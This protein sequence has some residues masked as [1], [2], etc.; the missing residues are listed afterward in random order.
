M[1]LPMYKEWKTRLTVKKSVSLVAQKK[2]TVITARYVPRTMPV[3]K[4]SLSFQLSGSGDGLT[5]SFEIVI[6]VPESITYNQQLKCLIVI[7]AS[8]RQQKDSP[9]LRMAIIKTIKGEKS[10]FHISAMSMNPI[11]NVLGEENEYTEAIVS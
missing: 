9:S 3:A 7:I 6:I 1:N 5:L 8:N 10:K 11:C 4:I 2:T